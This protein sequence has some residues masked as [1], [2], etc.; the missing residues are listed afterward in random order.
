M[1][2]LLEKHNYMHQLE[3]PGNGYNMLYQYG[4]HMTEA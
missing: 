3:G 2:L 4:Y 1:A